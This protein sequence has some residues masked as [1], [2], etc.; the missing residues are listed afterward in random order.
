MN[1]CLFCKII[2][3]ELP[4][5]RIYEDS[6]TYAFLDIAKD[7]DGHILVVPKAH[8]KNILDCDLVT[9][10]HV[11]AATK[12]ISNYLVEKC[13]YQGVNLLNASD[14]C[15]GQSVPHFHIHVIP[16]KPGDGVDAWP[17]LSGAELELE[18]V[19][20]K[21]KMPIEHETNMSKRKEGNQ[22]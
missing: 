22:A 5:Y 11:M 3:G 13:G 6:H 9:L 18:D 15:A 2:K 8:K 19:Y 4:S 1:D 17:Q 21:L 10:N 12:N 20:E 16:R 14:E 7:A